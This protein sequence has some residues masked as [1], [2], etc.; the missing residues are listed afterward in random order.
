MADEPTNEDSNQDEEDFGALTG[1]GDSSAEDS[2]ASDMGSLPPLSDFDST[3]G[4]SGEDSDLPPLETP[5]SS[6]GDDEGPISGLPPIVDIRVDTPAVRPSDLDTPTPSKPD[7]PETPTPAGFDTPSD[8]LDSPEPAG[9]GFQDFAADSDFSPETPEIGPGPDSDIETPMFDSAFGGDSDDFST[10][11]TGT[12][13]PTQSMETPLFGSQPEGGVG[14]DDDAFGVATPDVGADSGTPVPDFSP[15][16]GAGGPPDTGMPAGGA[17]PKRRGGAVGIL[18]SVVLVVVGLAIGLGAF[19]YVAEKIP[20][21]PNPAA[22]ELDEKDTEIAQLKQTIDRLTRSTRDEETLT[23]KQVDKLL[24]DYERVTASLTEAQTQL[25]AKQDELINLEDSLSLVRA[26]IEEKSNA[27][28]EAQETL[29]DIRNES[30]ITRARHEGLLAENERLSEVVS[31]L[32]VANERRQATKDTLLHNV[33]LLVVQIQG[34]SP[35]A[36]ER[37]DYT[38]R[39]ARV[40]NLRD[41]VARAKWVDPQLLDEYTNLYLAE[42]GIANSREYFFARIPL[43][44]KLGNINFKW[45]ECLMNGNWSVYFRTIDGKDIGSYENAAGSGPPRYEFREDLPGGMRSDILDAIKASRVGDYKEKIAVLEQKQ[46]IYDTKSKYQVS[47][48]SL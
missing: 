41:K 23:Q 46:E 10:G 39:L 4:E 44:D 28:V 18:I 7:E 5:E 15:D 45:A 9:L 14:F 32:E 8:A 31:G 11:G 17:P 38:G 29:D 3:E 2:D 34:G 27:F 12:S 36:P 37:Y 13:A 25:G 48:G 26:D 42:L 35:L 40:G 6:E 33:D 21:L 19:P 20:F 24:E 47:F 1:G 22:V 43:H 16:T 30:A